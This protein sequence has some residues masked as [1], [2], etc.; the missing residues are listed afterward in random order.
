M[1]L[2]MLRLCEAAPGSATR[3]VAA[4]VIDTSCCLLCRTVSSASVG[5]A[6]NEGFFSLLSGDAFPLTM[7]LVIVVLR[8][9][10]A[11][12]RDRDGL[13]KISGKRPRS[14]DEVPPG[15]MA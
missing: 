1:H 15:Y 8:G 4:R 3:E 2:E 9:S 12:E 6:S 13:T 14:A 5:L 10:T 7:F 11:V